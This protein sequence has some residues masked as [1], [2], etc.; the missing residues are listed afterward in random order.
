[1]NADPARYEEQSLTPKPD[2]K[3]GL[4]PLSL[5]ASNSW[6]KQYW[7]LLQLQYADYRG[8]APFLLLFG[9][10]MPLGLFWLL[11]SYVELNET[12]TWLIAGNLV[13]SVSYGS[14][15]FAIQRIAIMKMAGEMD[16][17]GSLPIGKS[18]FITALFT[19]GLFS[20]VPGVIS[21]ILIG[22]LAIGLPLQVL[23]WSLPLTL[24]TAACL[25]VIGASV[26]SLV[27]SMGQLNL[28]F[29]LSYVIVTFLCPV[30]VPQEK[31]PWIFKFT[32]YVL[33]PGQAAIALTDALSSD[34]GSRFWIMVA[35]LFAWLILA[36]TVGLRKLDWRKD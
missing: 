20:T 14:V 36:I 17:Y 32:S 27:K 34:Y 2:S 23:L 30:I 11:Q 19:L 6:S 28:Y 10:V 4:Q 21:N 9:L 26:G 33:P 8:N 15:N 25:T 29:Y 3:Q 22:W 31:L 7:L 35:A 18:S 12:A 5:G 1:M 13:M 16:F 24:L